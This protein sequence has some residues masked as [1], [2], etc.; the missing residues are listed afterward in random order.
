MIDSSSTKEE[1]AEEANKVKVYLSGPMSGL[2]DSNYPAFHKAAAAL[3]AKGYEV[4]SPAE[5][6]PAHGAQTQGATR[7]QDTPW[8]AWLKRGLRLM[9]KSDAVFVLDGWEQS[10][11]ASL[12]VSIAKELQ[13]PIYTLDQAWVSNRRAEKLSGQRE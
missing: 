11:G 1:I 8:H 7:P 13:M 3:R 4:L 10:R 12:E 2:P 5:Y 6:K 9:L